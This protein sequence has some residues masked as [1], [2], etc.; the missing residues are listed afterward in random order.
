MAKQN[1]RFSIAILMALSLSTTAATP[2]LILQPSAAGIFSQST[3]A[4]QDTSAPQRTSSSGSADVLVGTR[5]RA[6]QLDNKKIVIS[7]EETFAATL[8]TTEDVRSSRGT[9]L[10]PRGTRIEGEFRP[11]GDRS[12]T[13]FVARRIIFRDGAER[14]LDATSEIV[15]TRQKISK[16]VNT[17]PIW[18]GALV[19]GGAAAIISSLVTDV[20][21]F[22]VLGGAGA[23]ALAGYLIGGRKKTEVIAIDPAQQLE[24][25]LNS[26]LLLSSR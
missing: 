12:G 15:D 23:G 13:Q 26:D 22:K 21:I 1:L 2:L 4:P 19:G 14:N 25:T 16:G 5:V 6:V 8:A 24:L 11:A 18:Q 10:I 7:P 3:S 17:D 9:V 20:G